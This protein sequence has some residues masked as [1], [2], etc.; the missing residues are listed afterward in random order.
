METRPRRRRIPHLQPQTILI[1]HRTAASTL[2]T[3]HRTRSHCTQRTN[4]N[5]PSAQELH[6][7]R[8]TTNRTSHSKRIRNRTALLPRPPRSYCKSPIGR[9]SPNFHATLHCS[10]TGFP[11]SLPKP[12]FDFRPPR[13]VQV[14]QS[15]LAQAKRDV[16]GAERWR[17]IRKERAEFGKGESEGD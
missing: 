10:S 3:S 17:R 6:L 9:A 5:K 8:C 15:S 12:N 13:H 16:R 11:P 1:R 14:T 2:S 7:A 4:Q